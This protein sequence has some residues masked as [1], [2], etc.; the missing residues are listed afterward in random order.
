[1]KKKSTIHEKQS[2]GIVIAAVMVLLLLARTILTATQT[3]ALS[4]F[5]TNTGTSSLKHGIRD[6]VSVK[7]EHRDQH[8][9]QE[10]LCYR[11]NTCRQSN[12]G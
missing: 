11:T 9:N 12:V 3:S 5:N 6:G 4:R 10:N 8:M 1:L 7:L 2:M